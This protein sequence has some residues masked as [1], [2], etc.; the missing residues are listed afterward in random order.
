M[1]RKL[2]SLERFTKRKFSKDSP[3]GSF[4]KGSLKS[5]LEAYLIINVPGKCSYSKYSYP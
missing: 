4:K 3:N 1:I 2:E 5:K